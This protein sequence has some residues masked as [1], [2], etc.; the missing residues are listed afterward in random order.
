MVFPCAFFSWDEYQ[1]M[2]ASVRLS[3]MKPG[4]DVITATG[5]FD[6]FFQCTVIQPVH[7]GS[8]SISQLSTTHD[9]AV[10]PLQQQRPTDV[11]IQIH[12][13]PVGPQV[14]ETQN[15]HRLATECSTDGRNAAVVIELKY[16]FVTLD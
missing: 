10:T 4:Y 14:M 15:L 3:S 2:T 12:A 11:S 13:I 1:D 7:A 9:P 5:K 8:G 16:C 6:K